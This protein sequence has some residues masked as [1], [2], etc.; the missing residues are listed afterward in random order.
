MGMVKKES[1][2]NCEIKRRPANFK[3]LESYIKQG[4]QLRILKNCIKDDELLKN[5]L[6]RIV[7]AMEKEEEPTNE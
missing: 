5:D 2:T 4:E 7:R 3:D 6:V 1:V